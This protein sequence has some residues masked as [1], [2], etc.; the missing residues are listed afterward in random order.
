M[1]VVPTESLAYLGFRCFP[2]FRTLH[3]T[4]GSILVLLH[5]LTII[6]CRAMNIF[7]IY[8]YYASCIIATF[9]HIIWVNYVVM[10][11][12]NADVTAC[13]NWPNKND[14]QTTYTALNKHYIRSS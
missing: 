9:N 12:F 11:T 8:G 13:Q 10:A 7:T 5:L 14:F 1:I 4:P 2:L 6:I 3:I